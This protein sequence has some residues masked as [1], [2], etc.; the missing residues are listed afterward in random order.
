MF[1]AL[2]KILYDESASLDF[3]IYFLHYLFKIILVKPMPGKLNS[4]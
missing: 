2:I 1:S 3:S 4:S